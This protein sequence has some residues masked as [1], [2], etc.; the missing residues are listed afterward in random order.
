[1]PNLTA[2]L[3]LPAL[4]VTDRLPA[5]RSA[6]IAHT[7]DALVVSERSN[8][9]WLTGFRGSSGVV[10][11]TAEDLVVFTDGRYTQQ[12]PLELAA[13]Q[14]PGRV[15]RSSALE[16]DVAAQLKSTM[17]VGL[18]SRAVRWAELLRW[19]QVLPSPP[20]PV[21]S[22]IEE[23]RAVKDE[24]ELARIGAAA[25]ITDQALAQCLEHLVGGTSERDFAERLNDRMRALG[26][27]GPAYETIVASGPNAAHP[28]ARPSDR[29][30]CDGD[31]VI[32]DV[33]A[34]VDGYRSDMTRTFVIGNEPVGQT[35]QLLEVVIAAQ[36]AGLATVAPGC[37]ARAVDRACRQVIDEAGFGELFAHGTGHG[38]GLDIHELPSINHASAAILQPGSVLTVEPGVYLPS[39]GGVRVEDLVVVTETGCRPLTFSPQ[40][41]YEPEF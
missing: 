6:M 39:V 7:L 15:E 35:R 27:N 34:V 12:A 13:A 23:L 32:V 37:E 10:L 26:A 19:E 11:V 33:G 29:A 38:V 20:V 1:M 9:R 14:C 40:P 5:V 8:I 22:L 36:K 41:S 31:L 2:G 25:A 30:F 4:L 3:T 21:P 24:A 18:E 28:H 17:T 16:R